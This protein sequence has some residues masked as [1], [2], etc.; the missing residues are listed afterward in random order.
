MEEPREET[1]TSW[2]QLELSDLL[3]AVEQSLDGSS[4][5]PDRMEINTAGG[6]EGTIRI[7]QR[8]ADDAEGYFFRY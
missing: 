7:H 6:L 2:E 5:V 4:P 3:R 8:G 1:L